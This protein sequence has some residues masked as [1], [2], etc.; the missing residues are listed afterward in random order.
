M[1]DIPVASLDRILRKAGCKRV[2][3]DAAEAL[4][5]ITEDFAAEIAKKASKLTF[6]SGRQTTSRDDVILA[7]RGL[8]RVKE[9]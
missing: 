4:R 6:H 9:S 3:I 2:S 5:E 7:Y 8:K 1:T